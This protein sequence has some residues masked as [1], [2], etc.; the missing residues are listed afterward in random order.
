MYARHK[1]NSDQ[2]ELPGRARKWSNDVRLVSDAYTSAK[3]TS[4]EADEAG[5]TAELKYIHILKG[6]STMGDVIR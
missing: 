5:T 6:E 4:Y 1:H 3:M 2:L